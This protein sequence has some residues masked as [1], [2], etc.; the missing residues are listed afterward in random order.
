MHGAPSLYFHSTTVVLEKTNP[1]ASRGMW[2]CRVLEMEQHIM[3]L[4]T[5]KK[6]PITIRHPELKPTIITC[7]YV[8]ALQRGLFFRVSSIFAAKVYSMYRFAQPRAR[9]GFLWIAVCT[10]V[11]GYGSAHVFGVTVSVVWDSQR[12]SNSST[13]PLCLTKT[14]LFLSL[15]KYHQPTRLNNSPSTAVQREQDF[16]VSLP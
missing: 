4:G 15:H 16:S 9:E 10:Q 13:P 5:F 1:S 3:K 12:C 14:P 6:A 2:R 7:D 8:C 11:L